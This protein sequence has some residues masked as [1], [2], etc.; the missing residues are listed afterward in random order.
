[1]ARNSTGLGGLPGDAR[2]GC[3]A[4]QAGVRGQGSGVREGQGRGNVRVDGVNCCKRDASGRAGARASPGIGEG[5]RGRRGRRAGQGGRE[6]CPP[7]ATRASGQ[8]VTS[9]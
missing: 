8:C 7:P 1:M 6:S 2:Q 5:A 9:P 3:A 4:Q